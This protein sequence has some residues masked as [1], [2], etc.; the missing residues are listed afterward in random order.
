MQILARIIDSGKFQRILTLFKDDPEY[1]C[2]YFIP[3]KNTAILLTA[4]ACIALLASCSQTPSST[5]SSATI[6]ETS[7]VAS[8]ENQD[9]V[10]VPVSTETVL[11]SNTTTPVSQKTTVTPVVTVSKKDTPAPQ[12][13]SKTTTKTVSYSTP[14]HQ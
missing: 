12:N 10:T 5:N 13:N 6:P 3:M 11:A 8:F 14:S 7:V 9:I 1:R 4:F 2:T